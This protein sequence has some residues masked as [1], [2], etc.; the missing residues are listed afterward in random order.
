[1]RS[2]LAEA[3]PE[4]IPVRRKEKERIERVRRVKRAAGKAKNRK[5]VKR[6]EMGQP[7]LYLLMLTAAVIAT[8][9][10][11]FNYLALQNSV[12]SRMDN[13][14][15]LET[16]LENM[17]TE[18]DALEQSID[19]AVDLNEVYSIAVNELGMVHAGRDNII[20][21]ERTENEYVKQGEDIL[22]D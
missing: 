22:I 11:C 2:I 20:E 4:Y 21:Y 14:E 18:N 17:R 6:S 1:M 3:Y 5:K 10:I 15:R 16:T 13:I 12:T 19:T 7:F 9:Y 8:I